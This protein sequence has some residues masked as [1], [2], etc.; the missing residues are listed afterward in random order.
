MLKKLD[1]DKNSIYAN[2]TIL[3]LKTVLEMY[4]EPHFD[5]YVKLVKENKEFKKDYI[6]KYVDSI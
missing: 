6:Q 5:A 3:F 1:K 2:T 4:G